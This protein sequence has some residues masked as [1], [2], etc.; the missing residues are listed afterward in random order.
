LVGGLL[1]PEAPLEAVRVVDGGEGL[2][3]SP[4]QGC[5][6]LLGRS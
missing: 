2:G 3:L 1:G 5:R 4:S 6:D